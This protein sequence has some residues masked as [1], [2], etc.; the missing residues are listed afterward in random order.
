MRVPALR[1]RLSLWFAASILLIVTPVLVSLL[2]IQWRSMRQALDHHLEED[3]EVAAEMLVRRGGALAWRSDADRDLGYNAGPRRW[4]EA[5]AMAGG[6]PA[7]V[8]GFA[9][10]QDIRAALDSA[11][12][13]EGYRTLRTPAG[14]HVRSLSA[15]RTIGGELYWIRVV[16]TEDDLRQDLQRLVLLFSFFAI[17]A[18]LLAAVAGHAISGRALLPLKRM[19]ERARI[20]SADRLSERLPVDNSQDELGQLAVVFN[21][22]FSRLDESFRRL[23]QFTADASHELRTPLTAIRSV[24]EVGLRQARSPEAYREVIGSMLE[25]TDHLSRLVDT[26]LTLSRW[27][28]GRLGPVSA[29]VDLAQMVTDVAGQLSVLAEDRRID[30]DARV[31]D[32]IL[33]RT[34]PVLARQALANVI[35]N[36]IKFTPDGSRIRLNAA[37]TEVECRIIVDDE[38]PGIPVHERARVF[39]RFYRIEGRE[40]TGSGLG[41]AIVQWAMTAS[42][43]R[44]EIDESPSG[45][46]RVVLVWPR[47]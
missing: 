21:D 28:S 15:Q 47:S 43:G 5:Y 3:L 24:G 34:D 33:V 16:R 46:A 6:P 23:K 36:A 11:A 9:A 4:V 18:T 30:L 37:C 38:G 42:Q 31:C 45:G 13:R 7:F 14:A 20:I 41:L 19:A 32:S 25:E 22:T 44:I 29:T 10:R 2:T 17:V 39:E 12:L 27:E 35:D 26:L 40:R 1:T 8:R